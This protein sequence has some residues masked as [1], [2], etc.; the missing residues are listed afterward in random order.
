MS[1]F[2]RHYDRRLKTGVLLF[3]VLIMAVSSCRNQKTALPTYQSENRVMWERINMPVK[4]KLEAPNHFT[5]SGTAT[6]LRDTSIVFSLRMLGLEVAAIQLD[7]DSLLVIDKFHKYYLQAPIS[8]ISQKLNLTL[9]DIQN[10]LL[11][12]VP[13]YNF[14]RTNSDFTAEMIESDGQIGLLTISTSGRAPFTI[15]YGASVETPYGYFAKTL[16]ANGELGKNP[17]SLTIEWSPDKAKWNEEVPLRKISIGKGY[18]EINIDN[19]KRMFSIN[20]NF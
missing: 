8:E 11:G 9:S 5:I 7:R 2:P 18:Q 3:L 17:L 15:E 10:L 13:D 4:L 20:E 16:K 19:L 6:F 12:R 1:D 14:S